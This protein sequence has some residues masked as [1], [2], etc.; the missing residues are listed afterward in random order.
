MPFTEPPS[1]ADEDQERFSNFVGQYGVLE[2]ITYTDNVATK[3]GNVPAWDCIFWRLDGDKLVPHSG[4][5]IFA[6]KLVAQL[7]VAHRV[8]SPIAG[9]VIKEGNSIRITTA[10]PTVMQYLEELYTAQR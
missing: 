3:F 2:P 9:E 6:K 8:K 1:Y 10:P 7:N 4:I 5:R